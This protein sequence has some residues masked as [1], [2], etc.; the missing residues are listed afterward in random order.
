MLTRAHLNWRQNPQK[1]GVFHGENGARGGASAH[2]L[3]AGGADAGPPATYINSMLLPWRT[4]AF[5]AAR[6][7]AQDP[8]ARAKAAQLAKQ[9]SD[10]ARRIASSSDPARAAGQAV[11]RAGQQI[12]RQLR[13]SDE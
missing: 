10:E 2:L 3:Q 5:Y 13:P 7:L 8:R 6:K 9:T 11:R 1:T 4:L 12:R